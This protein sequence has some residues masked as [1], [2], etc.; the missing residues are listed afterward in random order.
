[1]EMNCARNWVVF[2][3]SGMGAT[4]LNSKGSKGFRSQ[5]IISRRIHVSGQSIYFKLKPDL[6]KMQQDIGPTCTKHK[7]SARLSITSLFGNG[8]G[9]QTTSEESF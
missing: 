9:F 1:M 2:S 6:V 7:P 3:C 4:N 5:T 8:L